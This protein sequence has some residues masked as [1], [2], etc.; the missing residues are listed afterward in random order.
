MQHGKQPA[1]FH[2]CRRS[3]KE[4]KNYECGTTPSS[5]NLPAHSGLVQGRTNPERQYLETKW[6]LA[7]SVEKVA[8]LLKEVLPVSASTNYETV[9]EHLHT[10]AERMEAELGEERLPD[11]VLPELDHELPA[12]DGPMTVGLMAAMCGPLTKRAFSR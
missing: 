3:D 12:P 11:L 10:M 4:S 7:D 5:E 6:G 9:R 2:R 8:N 1:D